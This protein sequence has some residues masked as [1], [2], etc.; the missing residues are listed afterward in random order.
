MSHEYNF[1][2]YQNCCCY[3][4]MFFCQKRFFFFTAVLLKLYE[5]YFL[6][7]G[8]YWL[9]QTKI[10][11]I[12][13]NNIPWV[14][15]VHLICITFSL[16]SYHKLGPFETWGWGSSSVRVL[17]PAFTHAKAVLKTLKGENRC[18]SDTL[19]PVFPFVSFINGLIGE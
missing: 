13:L 7:R 5:I 14:F 12:L 9:H 1:F 17:V 6:L 2:N 16:R 10:L 19:T 3:F 11:N 15:S 8:Y 4:K 18:L